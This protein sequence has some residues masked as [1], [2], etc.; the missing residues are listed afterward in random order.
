MY[1]ITTT[2]LSSPFFGK[3]AVHKLQNTK[4]GRRGFALDGVKNIPESCN[5]TYGWP[6]SNFEKN[7][8]QIL[9]SNS[10]QKYCYK[11][12]HHTV[13]KFLN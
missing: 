10:P 7:I 9:D 12:R 2:H 8:L 11:I 13:S 3:G 1:Y 4:R 5:G 6:Q